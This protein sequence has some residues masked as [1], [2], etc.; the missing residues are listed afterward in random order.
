[1]ECWYKGVCNQ[2]ADSCE[3]MC[4]RYTEMKYLMEHSNL[5]EKRMYPEQL[6]PMK[7]DVVAFYRLNTVRENIVD[8]VESGSNLYITSATT[9]NGKTSWAIKLMHKYFDAIWDG[10]GLRPRALFIHVPTYLL[11]CKDFNSVDKDF[12]NLK[13]LAQTVDLVVWDDIASTGM[14]A[15]DYSSLLVP[16]DVR[17]LN[18]KAN[19]FTG[20]CNTRSMMDEVL[21]TK[22]TSRVWGSRTEVIEFKGSDM[23]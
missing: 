23:R 21:G 16:L 8:F 10:N 2:F 13:Q 1:M 11:K 4:P 7:C 19:I 12:E 17:S 15:Y 5:P 9:G 6:S 20:N 22:L 18:Y 3:K 14:S